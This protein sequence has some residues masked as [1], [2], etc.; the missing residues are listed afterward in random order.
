MHIYR[1]ER[2]NT[3]THTHTHT[4]TLRERDGEIMYFNRKK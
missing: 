1:H 2:V 4:H 3:H